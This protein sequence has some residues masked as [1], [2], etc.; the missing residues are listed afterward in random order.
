MKNVAYF[1]YPEGAGKATS[2]YIFSEGRSANSGTYIIC[3]LIFCVIYMISVS[4]LY[5]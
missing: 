3:M 4:Y 2:R 1:D 5:V